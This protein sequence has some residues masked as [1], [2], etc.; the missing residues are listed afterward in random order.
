MPQGGGKFARQDEY[1]LLLAL[2]V[3]TV[4]EGIYTVVDVIQRPPARNAST[5]QAIVTLDDTH[6]CGLSPSVVGETVSADHA[7]DALQLALGGTPD[8]R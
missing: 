3:V 1:T 4:T 8:A 5:S 7:N 6:V 2:Q